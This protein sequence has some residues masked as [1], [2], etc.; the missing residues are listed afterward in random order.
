[1]LSLITLSSGQTKSL[2]KV[3]YIKISEIW[4]FGCALF[5]FASLVEF[6]FVNM[7]FRRRK[8]CEL[9]KVNSKY[10]FKCTFTPSL[11][12]NEVYRSFSSLNSEMYPNGMAIQNAV[13]S[14]DLP[15]TS[16]NSIA[17]SISNLEN[18]ENKPWTTMS[19]K[20][21]A[22]WIDTRC[23]VAFPIAFLIFNLFF[24]QIEANTSPQVLNNSIQDTTQTVYNNSK[25]PESDLLETTPPLKPTITISY[26]NLNQPVE[27]L[28]SV[29]K[30]P[31][32]ILHPVTTDVPITTTTAL[33]S[34]NGQSCPIPNNL[35]DLTQNQFSQILTNDCRYDKLTKPHSNGP[36]QVDLQIDVR[37]IEAADQL[38][39]RVH[40]HVQYSY[41]DER[42]RYEDLSPRRGHML[43]EEA[44]KSR[45]WVP[46]LIITNE[47][48]VSIM[49]F[50]GKDVYISISPKG[51][52][53]YSYRLSA[54]IYCWMDLKK[55][56]FDEQICQLN[57]QS[58]TYNASQLILKWEEP[59][60][61]KVASPLHLTEFS[62][63]DFNTIESTK[64]APIKG[65]FSGNFSTL[66]FRFNIAREVGYYIIDYFIP[67]IML[68][69]TSWVT[70]WLQADNTAPRVTLGT[71][72]MLS[73]ITLASGQT[74][75]LPKVS[76]IKVSE[77]WFLGC[78]LFIFASMVEFAFVNIIWRRRKK[79]EL[80]KV[81]SKYILK[82]TLTPR[83]ARRELQQSNSTS[84]LYKTRSCSS[85]NSRK[86]KD[87]A[88][89]NTYNNYLTVHSFATIPKITT[90]SDENLMPAKEFVATAIDI[91]ENDP[92]DDEPHLMPQK[93]T[94]MTP[95]EVAN[96][97]DKKSRVAFPIAFLIFNVLFWIIVL[98]M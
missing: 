14:T 26:P 64:P 2:P 1:M 24:C 61:V 86:T 83:L 78:S 95:Q 60:P 13:L 27:S 94:T 3:S 39:L 15:D 7:I 47:R 90:Q 40:L 49:G 32:T 10:V 67:S 42:L 16:R 91:P 70:F 29:T 18:C 37:H 73:F 44:L 45:I 80:K 53:I 96:W 33:P 76:Y 56:P 81:N 43:G 89:A 51:E 69:S 30:E 65:G 77:V 93:W 50:E 58:W 55:F 66:T 88:N 85:L 52:V 35:D 21:V 62:L 57:F 17:G 87:E 36:L 41:L 12:R 74:K 92:M 19:P 5:I 59:D 20:D 98:V 23:R 63:E 38:Q 34:N 4:F 22:N 31:T 97:I 71:S 79:V 48:D 84:S 75:T 72:T 68:V 11:A 54:T 82:S 46:H 9:K 6:A 8:N 25:V 28:P